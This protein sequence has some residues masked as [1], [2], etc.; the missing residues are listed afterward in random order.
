MIKEGL[1]SFGVDYV[2]KQVVME[3]NM[4]QGERSYVK[5]GPVGAAPHLAAAIFSP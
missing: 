4:I 5:P 1:R 2:E 3:H